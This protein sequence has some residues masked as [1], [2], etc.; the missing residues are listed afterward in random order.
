MTT[1]L[2]PQPPIITARPPTAQEVET[3]NQFR[4]QNSQLMERLAEVLNCNEQTLCSLVFAGHGIIKLTFNNGEEDTFGLDFTGLGEAQNIIG[5]AMPIV[6]EPEEEQPDESESD[7]SNGN[8]S[9]GGNGGNDDDN[10]S[11]QPPP[12]ETPPPPN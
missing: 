10:G 7:D 11:S 9:N 2:Q 8:G 6:P 5:E 4:D 12:E 1:T 3:F